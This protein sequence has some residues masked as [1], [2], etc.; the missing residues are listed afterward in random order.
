MDR[1]SRPRPSQLRNLAQRYRTARREQGE[2]RAE[3]R[4]EAEGR[5]KQLEER[6]LALESELAGAVSAKEEA[7]RLA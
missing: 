1:S 2:A 4:R 3:Q 5:Q 7:E 6:I